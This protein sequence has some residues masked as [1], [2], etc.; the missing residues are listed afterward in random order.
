MYNAFLWHAAE[1]LSSTGS[2]LL[3]RAQLA[4]NHQDPPYNQP[5]IKAPQGSTLL[6]YS[7]EIRSRPMAAQQLIIFYVSLVGYPHSS[8]PTLPILEFPPNKRAPMAE[9]QGP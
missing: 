3:W 9:V 6:P 2:V 7:K 4:R 5:E 1:Q 8:F